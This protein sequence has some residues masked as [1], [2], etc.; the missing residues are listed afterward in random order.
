MT[1]GDSYDTVS[2]V[3]S[4]PIMP[5][6][7]GLLIRGRDARTDITRSVVDFYMGEWTGTG[8]WHQLAGI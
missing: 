4:C 3:D 1:L 7:R 6:Y 5:D 2:T 8:N